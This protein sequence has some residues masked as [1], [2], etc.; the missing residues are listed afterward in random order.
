V[1]A[2][3]K[4]ERSAVSLP[5][6]LI[7][8]LVAASEWPRPWV[9]VVAVAASAGAGALWT[10]VS[11]ARRWLRAWRHWAL[12]LCLAPVPIVTW[13]ATRGRLGWESLLLAVA[14]TLWAAGFDIVCSCETIEADRQSGAFTIPAARWGT[15]RALFV[16]SVNHV[17]SLWLLAVFGWAGPV[18]W[19]FLVGVIVVSCA[20]YVFHRMIQP[21][22]PAGAA[23]KAAATGLVLSLVLLAFT[24]VDVLVMGGRAL[25]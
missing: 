10:G 9:L 19:L 11:A 12:G 16:A 8:A 21:E 17:A 15:R 18:G 24:A 22:R 13:V 3:S 2:S 7:S 1:I 14:L 6:A 5:F 20:L 4:F 23:S 25:I